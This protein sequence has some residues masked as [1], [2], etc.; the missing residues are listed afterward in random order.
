MTD[1]TGC[2][3]S[4][5]NSVVFDEARLLRF[6][7]VKVFFFD[8]GDFWEVAFKGKTWIDRLCKKGDIHKFDTLVYRP[9]DSKP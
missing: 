6:T 3:R 1:V 2:F 7:F 4:E 9:L 5:E 8:Q